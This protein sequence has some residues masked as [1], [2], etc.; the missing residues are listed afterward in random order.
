MSAYAVFLALAFPIAF[1]TVSTTFGSQDDEGYV[2]ISLK[3]FMSGGALYHSVFSQYGPFP[4]ELWGA[5]YKI[6]GLS[7]T[8]NNGRLTAIVL[9]LICSL[10]IGAT[11]ERLTGSATIGLIGAIFGFAG[12]A[13]I[14]NDPMH[15]QA[16]A[17]ALV[18]AVMAAVTLLPRR[19]VLQMSIVG[20]GLAALVF[21]KINIG[22][23]LVLATLLVLSVASPR[24]RRHRWLVLALGVICVLMPLALMSK[25]LDQSW[26]QNFAILIALGIAAVAVCL[27]RSPLARLPTGAQDGAGVLVVAFVATLAVIAVVIVALGTSPYDLLEGVVIRRL[28]QAGVNTVPATVPTLAVYFG[29]IGLACAVGSTRLE[30]RRHASLLPGLIRVGAGLVIWL[31]ATGL[32]PFS[33]SPN[34]TGLGV[35][36]PLSWMALVPAGDHEAGPNLFTRAMLAALPV[37]GA[38]DAYPVAGDQVFLASVAFIPVGG[39]IL[40]DGVRTLTAWSRAMGERCVSRVTRIVPLATATL[41]G[42][43]TYQVLLQAVVNDGANYRTLKPLPFKGATMLRE[44]ATT[45]A[46]FVQVVD[47]LRAECDTFLSVPGLDSFYFWAHMS[48]PNGLNAGT[49]MYLLNTSEQQRVVDAVSHVR[50]L[51]L[52]RNPGVLNFWSTVAGRAPPNLPLWRFVQSGFTPLTTAG[53]YQVLIRKG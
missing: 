10:L 51:C 14:A 21:T 27:V 45:T 31:W 16:L 46:D 12:C 15:P 43:L 9:W 6:L 2:L 33:L 48:P 20:C 38:I 4:Y 39:V 32:F 18:F 41:L 52:I 23:S 47:T 34:P 1:F 13:V 17:L 3:Q 8:P 19:R 36:I 7:V 53:G 40:G 44:S 50:R 11:V 22:A 29:A 37:F 25:D 49:W 5:I 26:A 35:C 42:V 30:H 24:L 28:N